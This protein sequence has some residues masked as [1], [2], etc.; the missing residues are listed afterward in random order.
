[1]LQG[2]RREGLSLEVARACLLASCT[3]ASG[4]LS[5]HEY[6]RR[7]RYAA[8]RQGFVQP[9]C[10]LGD[11]KRALPSSSPHCTLRTPP[12]HLQARDSFY[13]CV[14][15]AG[16]YAYTPGSQIPSKC[17]ALRAAFEKSCLPSWV[18]SGMGQQRM[19][20]R[21]A[22]RA[23]TGLAMRACS[24]TPERVCRVLAHAVQPRAHAWHAHE[25]LACS[26]PTCKLARTWGTLTCWT[27]DLMRFTPSLD[28]AAGGAF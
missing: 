20:G 19:Q 2:E 7:P 12:S 25:R 18:R 8:W 1:M 5:G 23:L 13:Q 14:R 4:M 27:S 22:H 9:P 21:R 16:G 3:K 24:C 10:M 6:A 11:R 17:K 26:R 28:A 15:E